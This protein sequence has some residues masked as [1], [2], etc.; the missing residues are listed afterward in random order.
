MTSMEKRRLGLTDI[1]VSTIGLGCA[2]YWGKAQFDELNAEGLI[3]AYGV[4]S[5]PLLQ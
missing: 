1:Y 3:L 4:N 5:I 2:S